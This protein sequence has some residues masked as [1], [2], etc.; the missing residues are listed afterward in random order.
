MPGHSEEIDQA[1]EEGVALFDSWGPKAIIGDDEGKVTGVELVRC[2]SVLDKNDK[3]NPIYNEKETKR[4]DADMI[5]LAVG[6][7]ADLSILPQGM[8]LNPNGSVRV[9]PIT[10]ETTL[11]GVFAGGDVAFGQASVV[12]AIAAGKRAFVSIDRYL[13]GEDL[14]AGRY[15]RRA[16]RVKNPPKEGVDRMARETAPM[17]PVSE[18]RNNFKEVKTGFNED[19]A[20]LEAQRCMTCGS[21]ATIEY[22]EECQLCLFCERDCPQKAIYVSPEKKMTP[23]IAWG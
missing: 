11:P 6:Q 8:M 4:I 18:R 12:E 15:L 14:K 23:L 2:V 1:V 20:N 17:I 19:M 3:F 9:D 10:A 16:A 21:R 5:V 22:V 7:E 13:K